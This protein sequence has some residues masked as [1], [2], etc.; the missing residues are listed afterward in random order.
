MSL[1]DSSNPKRMGARYSATLEKPALDRTRTPTT[2]N[3]TFIEPRKVSSIS[4]G[5]TV[6]DIWNVGVLVSAFDP[7]SYSAFHPILTGLEP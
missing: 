5:P 6:L 7:P 4:R 3:L 2:F 1:E